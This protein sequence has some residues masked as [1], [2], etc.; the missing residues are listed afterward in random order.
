MFV[1][2]QKLRKLFN[3]FFKRQFC[4]ASGRVYM[5]TPVKMPA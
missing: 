1:L 2:G 5:A 3:R 4:F